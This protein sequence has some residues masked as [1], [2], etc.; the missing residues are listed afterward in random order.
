M[1]LANLEFEK[2]QFREALATLDRYEALTPIKEKNNISWLAGRRCDIHSR[3]GD[4][5]RAL[6]EAKRSTSGFYK[7]IAQRLEQAAPSA[8]QVALPVGFVRQ[9]HM[10]CAPATLSALSRYWA[11]PAD[12]LEMAESICYDGTPHHSQ[13]RWA[14]EHGW[15]VREFTVT[16][17][18]ARALLD[19]GVPFTLA[20]VHPGSSHL[21]AVLVTTMRAGRC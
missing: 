19:A 16:W 14:I 1:R 11:R 2:G 6:T 9:H 5:P 8:R 15:Y 18:C 20:T 10:T 12:H 17:D 3:L 13:R 21:Q 7:Q 4:L